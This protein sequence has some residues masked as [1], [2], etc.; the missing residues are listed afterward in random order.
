MNEKWVSDIT[1]I[2][3][4]REGCCYLSSI[5]DL[6]SNR[7]ILHKVGKVKDVELVMKTLEMATYMRGSVGETIIHTDR[8]SQYLSKEYRKYCKEN[9]LELE[10]GIRMIMR[11]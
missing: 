11:V 8:G 5:M 7:I 1:Y 3:S 9:K 4:E 2:H 10:K 6:K